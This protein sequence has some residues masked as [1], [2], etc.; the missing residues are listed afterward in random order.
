MKIR[1]DDA[2][3]VPTETVRRFDRTELSPPK[4]TGEGFL[5][6]QGFLTKV[7][8]FDY[9]VR[10]ENG[11]LKTFRELRPPEEV[12]K[13]ESLQS[14]ALLPVVEDH[15][16]D[17]SGQL[18]N[19]NTELVKSFQVGSVGH[20]EVA[21]D[22]VK[23]DILL[24]DAKVIDKVLA[25]KNQLSLGYTSELEPRSGV[26]VDASGVEHRFD[27]VQTNIVGNHV[28]IV[29]EARAGPTAAIRLD[30][31]D[32]IMCIDAHKANGDSPGEGMGM[33]LK[34][35][36]QEFEVPEPV[37][38]RMEELMAQLA[39][40]EAADAKA[41]DDG[42]R[43]A[44]QEP[45]SEMKKALMKAEG[46]IA[47][48]EAKIRERDEQDR[49]DAL[50]LLRADAAELL[51]CEKTEL[52]ELAEMDVRKKVLAKFSPSL[53]LDSASDEFVLGAYELAV[54]QTRIKKA[55]RQDT[56]AII[57]QTVAV[58][59][60]NVPKDTIHEAYQR[61]IERMANAWKP[62]SRKSAEA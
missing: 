36:E 62:K 21:G 28:A 52:S 57:N 31:Q 40:K 42:E 51:G 32:G 37:A 7:G 43:K 8:V 23:A 17:A 15:P 34:I 53:R 46:R 58:A 30:S 50:E 6:A 48:L 9:Q 38:R 56:A 2:V 18:T 54:E 13:P 11:Q 49:A 22:H 19:L 39:E 14:F 26:F 55:E 24:T 1:F 12:F 47:A 45:E 59:K 27:A 35:G 29:D 16:K 10:D 25:G 41:E 44:D 20:P 61:Q 60:D 5:R 3:A 4:R 33:I